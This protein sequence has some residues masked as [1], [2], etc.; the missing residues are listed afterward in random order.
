MSQLPKPQKTKLPKPRKPRG[1]PPLLTPTIR[2]LIC[3]HIAEGN[4]PEVAAAAAG[5]TSDTF[6]RWLRRGS[7]ARR[8]LEAAIDKNPRAQ[9]PLLDRPYYLFAVAL[10]QARAM[11]EGFCVRVISKAAAAGIWTAAAWRLERMYP[12][13]WGKAK[14]LLL[15]TT[16]D[17]SWR[18]D[19]PSTWSEAQLETFCMTGEL[20]QGPPKR[21]EQ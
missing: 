9:V 2:D 5:V 14:R 4:Y 11:G 16:E 17:A 15:E 12:E 19:D 1:R 6:Y 20:P 10:E 8:T 13:R 21:G 7:R 3:E 18:L